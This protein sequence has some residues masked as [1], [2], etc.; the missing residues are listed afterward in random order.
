MTFIEIKQ[1]LIMFI[2]GQIRFLTKQCKHNNSSFERV[3]A[4]DPYEDNENNRY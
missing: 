4:F 2:Y 1:H 3:L